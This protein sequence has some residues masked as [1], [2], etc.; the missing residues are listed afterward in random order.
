MNTKSAVAK[1]PTP[2]RSTHS[3][4]P[5]RRLHGWKGALIACLTLLALSGIAYGLAEVNYQQ[6]VT[7][8]KSEVENAGKAIEANGGVAD[9]SLSLRCPAFLDST[10]WTDFTCPNAKRTWLVPLRPGDLTLE[11]TI[12][13]AGGYSITGINSGEKGGLDIYLAR[14]P[15]GNTP[16][17]YPVPEG[18]EWRFFRVSVSWIGSGNRP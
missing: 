8:I 2:D 15:I 18:K 3:T 16:P 17:P 13:R 1:R 14:D 10:G 11:K 5:K 4:S 12:L 7:M 9:G 6:K